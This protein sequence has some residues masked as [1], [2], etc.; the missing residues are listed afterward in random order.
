MSKK[1]KN[2][3]YT[4]G[5]NKTGTYKDLKITKHAHDRVIERFVGE[6]GYIGENEI[7]KIAFRAKQK[8]IKI[9]NLVSNAGTGIKGSSLILNEDE[10]EYLLTHFNCRHRDEAVYLY[11]DMVWVFVGHR[12]KILKTVVDF[13]RERVLKWVNKG[14]PVRKYGFHREW[15]NDSNSRGFIKNSREA[16]R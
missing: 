9:N 14:K 7:R 1:Q 12:G 6:G 4:K 2:Q 16:L 15:S 5:L 10:K 11:N 13:N 8:G 3:K